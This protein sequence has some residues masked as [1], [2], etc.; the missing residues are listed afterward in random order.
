V[1][2]L[3]AN[4]GAAD[5]IATPTLSRDGVFQL[6]W[7]DRGTVILEEAR[8]PDFS[9]ARPIYTG[10]DN[11]TTLSGKSDGDY[12]YR[13]RGTLIDAI[14]EG[15]MRVEV[16]HHPLSRA[17]GFFALGAVVFIATVTLIVRGGRAEER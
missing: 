11:G 5:L 4:S 3:G 14:A 10:N 8:R 2:V 7:A 16:R 9:D 12:Y 15:E 17:L 6:T 13:V 1:G